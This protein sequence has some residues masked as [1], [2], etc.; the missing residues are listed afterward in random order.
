MTSAIFQSKGNFPVTKD[1]LIID[2]IVGRLTGRLSLMTRI[3]ILLIPGALFV[4]IVKTIS[5]ICGFHSTVW[6]A[7]CSD[8][9]CVLGLK[10]GLARLY[11][12]LLNNL[13]CQQPL[14]NIYCK[15]QTFKINSPFL[16]QN[17]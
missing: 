10:P 2:V 11:L 4:G 14:G 16:F 6:N 12:R 5:W 3:G 13:F 15:K 7:N 17:R 8:S 1:A 9:P